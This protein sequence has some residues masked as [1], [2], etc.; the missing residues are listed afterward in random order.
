MFYRINY[1]RTTNVVRLE[2]DSGAAPAALGGAYQD[3]GS[4]KHDEGDNTV[5]D[6]PLPGQ[7]V[8]ESHALYSHVQDALY[9]LEG[10][11]NMQ[12][13]IIYRD[14]VRTLG[15]TATLS[16]AVGASAPLPATTYVPTNTAEK[17]LT[18]VSADP[19]KA[20]VNDKGVVTGVAVGT[21]I[22]TITSK[23][24]TS[25]TRAV[26]VTVTA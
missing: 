2:S 20:T 17:G 22:V 4:F 1:N 12:I 18:Y 19:T 5:N 6:D 25:V 3:L 10:E 11:Q 24:D 15:G 23:D 13:Q 16:V 21:S 8:S 14:R 7:K 9:R 26:T